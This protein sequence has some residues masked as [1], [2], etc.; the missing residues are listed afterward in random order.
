MLIISC[1]ILDL[2]AVD[3]AGRVDLVDCDLTCIG[4]VLSVN[5][6]RAGDRADFSD[7]PLE[8]AVIGSCA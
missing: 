7:D 1:N 4:N 8:F 6:N 3:T 2:I 5:G